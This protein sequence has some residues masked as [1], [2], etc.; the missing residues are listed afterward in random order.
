MSNELLVALLVLFSMVLLT[1]ITV[2][3]I[4]KGR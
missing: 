1:L 3:E 4:R 2:V